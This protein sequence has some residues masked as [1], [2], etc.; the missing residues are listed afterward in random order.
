MTNLI[1]IFDFLS[2]E[3]LIK[4]INRI[5]KSSCSLLKEIIYSDNPEII[6]GI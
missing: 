1:S 2:L 3:Y 6:D 5:L 4:E